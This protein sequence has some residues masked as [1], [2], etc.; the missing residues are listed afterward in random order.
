MNFQKILFFLREVDQKKTYSKISKYS[1]E[2]Q[3]RIRKQ[4][5]D[6]QKRLRE[7]RKKE[8]I[9]LKKRLS[10]L[11]DTN[12]KLKIEKASLEAEVRTLKKFGKLGLLNYPSDKP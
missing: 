8:D 4:N 7:R 11:D 9:A 1:P 2:E 10:V 12:I 3:K 6:G 5:R